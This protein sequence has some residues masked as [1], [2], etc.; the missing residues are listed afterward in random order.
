MK[1]VKSRM[2]SRAGVIAELLFQ[3]VKQSLTG[4]IIPNWS[5]R[6]R[7]EGRSYS[8]E[9]LRGGAKCFPEI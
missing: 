8:E 5:L 1:F 4:S 6:W 9:P 2:I 3:I 7:R